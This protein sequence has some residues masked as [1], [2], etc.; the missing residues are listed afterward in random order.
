M[1]RLVSAGRGVRYGLER[2][3]RDRYKVWKEEGGCSLKGGTG[4]CGHG[5]MCVEG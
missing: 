3:T 4:R 1:G 2:L 5:R